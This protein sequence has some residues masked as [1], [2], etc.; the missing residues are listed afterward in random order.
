MTTLAEAVEA[1]AIRPFQADIPDAELTELRKR[2]N[3]IIA[4]ET[5]QPIE[6]VDVDTDRNYWMGPDE[7]KAYGIV[8]HIVSNMSEIG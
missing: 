8:S 4:R 6:K 7:A 3:A 5:G 1:T 2:I